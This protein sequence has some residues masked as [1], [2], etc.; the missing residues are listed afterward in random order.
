MDSKISRELLITFDPLICKGM[1]NS[2]KKI[3]L[4]REMLDMSISDE[5][6]SLAQDDQ[7]LRGLW[8]TAVG[9]AGGLNALS[10]EEFDRRAAHAGLG[11]AHR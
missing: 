3:G 9:R 11:R 5:L 7:R 1:Q 4:I 6:R 2:R 10:D 8:A